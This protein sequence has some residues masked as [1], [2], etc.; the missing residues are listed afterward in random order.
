MLQPAFCK[1]VI[2]ELKEKVKSFPEKERW[3]ALLHDEMSIKKGLV[4]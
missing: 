2:A 3:V 4:S 1:Q